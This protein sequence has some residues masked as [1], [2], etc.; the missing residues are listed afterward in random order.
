M[1]LYIILIN[2]F[3]FLRS[4]NMTV[5][6]GSRQRITLLIMIQTVHEKNQTYSTTRNS[7]F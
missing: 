4:Y 1:T 5:K 2:T 6:T 3:L 7:L